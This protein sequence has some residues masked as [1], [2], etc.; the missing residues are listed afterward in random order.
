MVDVALASNFDILQAR[1]EV[2]KLRGRLEETVGAALPAIVPTAVFEHVEG[3]V[4][5]TEGNLVGVGFNT[6]NASV[7][8]QWV[9][10]PGRV[11]YAIVAAK[12]RLAATKDQEQAV[13]METLRRAT[14]NK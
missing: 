7:A 8:I 14:G 6:F 1:E 5:A 11:I 2:I 13:V 3:K 4:R 12:K 10:N 9:I